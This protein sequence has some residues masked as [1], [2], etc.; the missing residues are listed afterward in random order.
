MPL[1]RREIRSRATRFARQWASAH[2]EDADAKPFWYEFF[3]VFGIRARTVGSYEVHVKKLNKADGYIDYF[4]PGTLL[5]E[6]K[7]K[8]RDLDRA[9][10]QAND[11]LHG[12][13]EHEKPRYLLV[14]DFARFV[15]RDLESGTVTELT[16]DELPQRTEVFDFI[17]GYEA[18][19]VREQ[20][21]VNIRAAELMGRLHD[22]LKATGYEGRTLEVYLVRLLFIL[23]ADDTG[24][25]ERDAF[26]NFVV[27]QTRED[28]TDLGPQLARL[29]QLLNTPEDRRPKTLDERLT[30]F[31]YINGRLFEEHIPLAEWDGAMRVTLLE[32]ASLDWATISPAIF[33]ALFQSAMDAKLRRNLGAH[34][35]SEQNIL[36]LI[37]PLFLDDLWAEFERVKSSR[38]KLRRFH[39]KLA[40]LRFLDPACGCGNFLVIT[41]REL[42]E[43]EIA[44]LRALLKGQQVVDVDK[45]VLLN[46]DRF[47]GIEIEEF[48]AQ[49]AQVALW[50]VDHQ[51][52]M[53]ISAAFGEYMVRIPLRK[54]ATIVC[55]NAL[56]TDWQG[57]LSPQSSLRSAGAAEQL[58][59]AH[60][61]SHQGHD[62]GIGETPGLRSQSLPAPGV[63]IRYD[64]ILGNPPFSGKKEQSA[65]QK[66]AAA[67][68]FMLLGGTASLDFVAAWFVKATEYVKAH[69]DATR[70]AFV[71]TNSI[72][73]GEQVGE[74][75]GWMLSSGMHID[76]AH[77]T[78][79]W[80]NEA[81]G[82]AAVHCVIIGF[83]KYPASRR[84]LFTYKDVN[85]SPEEVACT[86]I[87]P[88]L[89]EGA[90][91]I[92]KR[93]TTPL[94]SVPGIQK[95]SEAT[96]FG[97]LILSPEEK[98]ALVNAEPNARRW[99]RRIIGGE[100]LI[101]GTQ[102]WCLWLVGATP[103]E[104]KG[105]PLVLERVE[106]VRR[107][108]LASGKA[109]TR[110]WASRPYLFSED[111]Q[112]VRS[113]LAI[114]KVS[115]ERRPIMPIDYVKAE[116]I[117]S[118]SVLTV[119]GGS[120]YHF[121]V[122]TSSMHMAWMRAVC[123]RMK[124]DYQYSASIV[125]NNFPWP[126][127]PTAL[128]R[129]AG[130]Q[131]QA[132]E[133]AAQ[134]VLD[135]RA[136]FPTA[137]LADLYDPLTMPPNLVK[138]HQALDK[139]VD[140]CYRAQPFQS[141]AKR[142]E[143]LFELYEKYSAG[144]LAASAKAPAG[145]RKKAAAKR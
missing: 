120:L 134:G 24:I 70:C 16:L 53:R 69:G 79:R 25:F 67:P 48:P 108:R 132:V 82:V 113:Y 142:V 75:W 58:G 93:R 136:Q 38:D 106:R 56:R 71:A 42:R 6:H 76:F 77:Q 117:A 54:S 64:Y 62:A 26:Y 13:K 112:P 121:G 90:D 3:A 126:E 143:W 114:P 78:F 109:R 28:G 61:E 141:D 125:Y 65:E 110:E 129:Q 35:T 59:P 86:N 14:S 52:N 39:D 72:T 131:K 123:G 104:L 128:P 43:L 135:A 51:M 5:I 10:T 50:L 30:D 97:H 74:L 84:R 124:S 60:P 103:Q 100:E 9:F 115:S 145:R 130:A 22:E 98:A 17:A 47:Y 23:F 63:T 27:D 144:L 116:V 133:Q 32:C 19:P 105:M 101:N 12:I 2:N 140:K 49:I 55:A 44:V 95:G 31:K 92:V 29:F 20:D 8:G 41:Y 99:L 33:G 111:R 94:C 85:A 91:V 73:Q 15:L 66:A 1:S 7:S 46:V 40:N 139:A 80:S 137:S 89:V 96:D 37:K 87:S 81:R 68:V 57:L 107:D 138:A 34:Y 119:Q 122:M 118:G 21:P 4:W 36:K 127:A 88:Y 83:S 102:R 18:R 11:Y 45:L